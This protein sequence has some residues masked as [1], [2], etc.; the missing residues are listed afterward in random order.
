MFLLQPLRGQTTRTRYQSIRD[1]RSSQY[2]QRDGHRARTSNDHLLLV[3]SALQSDTQ[4]PSIIVKDTIVAPYLSTTNVARIRL[5]RSRSSLVGPA[6]CGFTEMSSPFL[7][8]VEVLPEFLVERY[9]MAAS[10][11]RE[12]STTADL[13]QET[14]RIRLLV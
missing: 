14:D 5:R 10:K 13:I 1:S 3:V 6:M 7:F 8:H 4:K 12:E 2:N 11:P 9:E